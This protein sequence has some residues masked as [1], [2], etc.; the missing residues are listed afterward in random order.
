MDQLSEGTQDKDLNL[1]PNL[2][3]LYLVS[4]NLSHPYQTTPNL[5]HQILPTLIQTHLTHI[6]IWQLFII[7]P[8]ASL[9]LTIILKA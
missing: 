7:F 8:N 2:T 3:K 1:P 6:N 5:T 4:P 9:F